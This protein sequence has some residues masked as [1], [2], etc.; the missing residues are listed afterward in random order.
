MTLLV[1]GALDAAGLRGE[2]TLQALL[3]RALSDAIEGV[4]PSDVGFSRIRVVPWYGPAEANSR[5]ITSTRIGSSARRKHRRNLHVVP[6]QAELTPSGKNPVALECAIFIYA[7]KEAAVSAAVVAAVQ[8]G[9]VADALKL[10][11]ADGI[12][13][14]VLYAH[15]Y[16]PGDT[17]DL[18]PPAPG[19]YAPPPPPKASVPPLEEPLYAGLLGA[20]CALLL[21]C[22]CAC[23]CSAIAARREERERRIRDAKILAIVE[24]PTKED[25]EARAF[26]AMASAIL[27]TV[28][29]AKVL[30]GA[31]SD[32]LL[33]STHLAH[34]R[35]HWQTAS[36]EPEALRIAEAAK[37]KIV[38]ETGELVISPR[39]EVAIQR[40]EPL[41]LEYVPRMVTPRSPPK[42]H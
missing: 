42:H 5:A 2:E 6:N 19:G 13:V 40:P 26:A 27:D 30:I 18:L 3:P 28:G 4:E 33:N 1:A 11:G 31:D 12:M 8:N 10:R 15:G 38:K 24:P 32:G 7:A 41:K 39:R 23:L 16:R 29:D 14:Y 37:H 35:W 20:G 22:L 34:T 21:V 36:E 9:R 25:E 17:V